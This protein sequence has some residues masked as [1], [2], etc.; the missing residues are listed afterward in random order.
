MKQIYSDDSE[1][2]VAEIVPDQS[3]AGPQASN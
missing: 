2:K 3:E 1:P